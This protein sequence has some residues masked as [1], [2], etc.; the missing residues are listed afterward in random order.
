MRLC[1]RSRPRILVL[2]A[3]VD[4][5]DQAGRSV[6]FL[7]VAEAL[8]S[9]QANLAEILAMALLNVVLKLFC[10]IELAVTFR[11]GVWVEFVF[12]PA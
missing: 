6:R 5:P 1:R 10:A 8:P 2:V 11:A 7:L 4:V 3:L 12:D 9:G